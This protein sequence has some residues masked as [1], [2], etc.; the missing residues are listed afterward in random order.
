MTWPKELAC[1]GVEGIPPETRHICHI[2]HTTLC[3]Y[4]VCDT[5]D[6]C[7]APTDGTPIGT[8]IR[9]A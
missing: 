7:D 6:T 2:C 4:P 5:C 3:F 1:N 8:S 9:T